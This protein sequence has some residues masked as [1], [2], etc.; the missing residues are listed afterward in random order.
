MIKRHKV[1]RK[2]REAAIRRGIHPRNRSAPQNAIQRGYDQRQTENYAE[3][4]DVAGSVSLKATA[5][6]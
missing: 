1:T 3:G 6:A 2:H 5:S 4:S